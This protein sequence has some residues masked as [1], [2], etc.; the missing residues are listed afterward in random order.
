MPRERKTRTEFQ[1]KVYQPGQ[2]GG[3]KIKAGC[4][5]CGC[6]ITSS[7]FPCCPWNFNRVLNIK[8]GWRTEIITSDPVIAELHRQAYAKL[9]ALQWKLVKR[10]V[11]INAKATVGLVN[12]SIAAGG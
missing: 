3:W 7:G 11:K 1:I 6:E 12:G 2:K 5:D 8:A 9:C 10:R 4:E